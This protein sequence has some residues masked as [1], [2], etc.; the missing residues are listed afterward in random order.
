MLLVTA[1]NH[2]TWKPVPSP[3]V[4]DLPFTVT[5]DARDA[6]SR[7]VTHFVGPVALGAGVGGGVCSRSRLRARLSR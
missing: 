3:Q 2:F 7:I 6:S 5:V 1:L 4:A